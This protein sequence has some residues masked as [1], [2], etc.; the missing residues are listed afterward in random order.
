MRQ[1]EKER[2][3]AGTFRGSSSQNKA[4]C[5]FSTL[6]ICSLPLLPS[7]STCTKLNKRLDLPGAPVARRETTSL[8]C[9]FCQFVIKCFRESEI[10][11]EPSVCLAQLSFAELVI[12]FSTWQVEQKRIGQ[13]DFVHLL[14]SIPDIWGE[15]GNRCV[16]LSRCATR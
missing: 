15:E 5:C 14:C 2:G 6:S 10:E 3:Q 9:F 12:S 7:A 11:R 4:F 16:C 13:E 8:P 1:E